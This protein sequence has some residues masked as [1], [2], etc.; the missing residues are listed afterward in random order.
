[1]AALGTPLLVVDRRARPAAAGS[2]PADVVAELRRLGADADLVATRDPAAEVRRAVA[3]GRRYLIVA[4][5]DG[6]VADAVAAVVDPQGA[7]PDVVLG[8]ATGGESDFARS[9]GLDR[10]AR[11]LARQ[12]V[13][14]TELT[15]DVGQVTCAGPGGAERSRLFV[16]VAQVGYGGELARRARRLRALGRAGTLLAAWGA[17]AATR[18]TPVSVALD[19]DVREVEVSDV[20]VANGQF[21]QRGMKIAPRALPDDARF[22]VQLFVGPPS[23]V[24]LGT[25]RILRGEHLPDPQ[26]AEYQSGTVSVT[27]GGTGDRPLAVEADGRWVGRTPATFTLRPKALRLKL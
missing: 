8:L 16:N 1:M 24:F 19:H 12:L 15:V 7:A 10:D 18:R 22:N 9:F 27:A 5:D 3:A 20:V 14:D 25:P 13:T 2:R 6:S 26:I 17:I 4:G 11:L 23:Q 21:F